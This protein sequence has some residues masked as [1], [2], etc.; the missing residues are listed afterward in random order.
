MTENQN[1]EQKARDSID[2][3]L[4]QAGWA[5]Q[6]A[7]KIDLNVG[8]GQAVR[9]YQT[10]IGPADYVL[11]VD[12][13]AVGVIEAKREDLAHKITEIE[14]Q[15][16]GYAAAKLKWINN[17]EPLPFLYES[18]GIITRFTDGRDPK[19]RSRE[20]FSFHRPETLK[21]WLSQGDSLRARL[22]HIPP[23]NPNH[24]PA[25]ELRLR[26][27]QETAITNLEESFKAEDRKS[28]V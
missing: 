18:T 25:K 15:T 21:E 3:L 26:D 5:V 7:K 23:L 28:V 1:P 27:C 9:E 24:L 6:H 19:P 12:K 8:L 4:K 2:E 13:Q 22:H 16:Q 20:V 11:F 10:D 14:S 17:K